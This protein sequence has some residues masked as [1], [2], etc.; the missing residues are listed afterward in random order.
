MNIKNQFKKRGVRQ[1]RKKLIDR[2]KE[3]MD[4]VE[5]LTIFQFK[6]SDAENPIMCNFFGCI[7]KL[8]LEEQRFGRKC[9]H[10]QN[11]NSF[12]VTKFIQYP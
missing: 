9:T 12:D 5:G 3:D 6:G 10:H 11:K 4:R 7:R 1:I 2:V 8:S